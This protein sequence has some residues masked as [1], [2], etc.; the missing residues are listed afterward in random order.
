MNLPAS[1]AP[2]LMKMRNLVAQQWAA[3]K[4]KHPAPETPIV[5]G[6]AGASTKAAVG[7]GRHSSESSIALIKT[8][9]G[10]IGVVGQPYFPPDVIGGS[11]PRVVGEEED[12]VWN[13]AAE[14]CDSERVH[15]V[16]QSAGDKIWYL[17]VRSTDLASHPASWCPLAA[18]LPGM[19][20]ALPAPVCYTYYGDD[21]ATM[22]SITDD[23]L[24]IYRGT[25]AIVRAKAERTARALGNAT[26]LELVEDRIV[27]LTP[28]PWYSVSLF[29]DR[30]RR[31]LAALAVVSALTVAGIAF[32]VWLLSSVTLITARHDLTEALNR[33]QDKTQKMLEQAQQLRASPL[34]E[35]L[36]SF[37]AVNEGLL[38]LNGFLEIYEVKKDKARWRAVV[39]A[40]VTADRINA[41]GGQTIE[42]RA[43]GTVIGNARQIEYEK[44]QES[45]R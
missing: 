23:G 27:A 4:H 5:D 44:A 37:D 43:D 10:A 30:A 11:C 35:Q 34:R 3:I 41:L 33:T 16:W 17:A 26:I 36:A 29:E 22:M 39:P 28:I 6:P 20:D 42:S 2:M 21:L 1:L 25:N 45:K 38:D 7:G 8:L 32:I 13:A 40:N 19:K 9:T 24:H 14:A 18:V 15:V 12:I 31:I